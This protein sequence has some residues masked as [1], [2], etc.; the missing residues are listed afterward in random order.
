MLAVVKAIF[1]RGV[2]ISPPA[3]FS[4]RL[5]PL[6]DIRVTLTLPAT[7]FVFLAFNVVYIFSSVITERATD[8]SAEP[9]TAGSGRMVSEPPPSPGA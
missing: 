8:G 2:P 5:A 4:A 6:K 9:F 7:V 3:P 1:L